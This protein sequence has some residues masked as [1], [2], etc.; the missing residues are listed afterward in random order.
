MYQFLALFVKVTKSLLDTINNVKYSSGIYSPP[1]VC[2][3]IQ[4]VIHHWN[5]KTSFFVKLFWITIKSCPWSDPLNQ[6]LYSSFC[7]QGCNNGPL[8]YCKSKKIVFSSEWIITIRYVKII[9][10]YLC[11]L[12][13]LHDNYHL[14]SMIISG[15]RALWSV[16]LSYEINQHEVFKFYGFCSQLANIYLICLHFLCKF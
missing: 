1:F 2:V 16:F 15:L 14:A 7:F 9:I 6:L 10:N 4:S 8:F 13:L 11:N 3:I 12:L 5:P